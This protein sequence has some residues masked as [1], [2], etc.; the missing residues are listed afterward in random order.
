M[1]LRYLL[2]GIAAVL[3]TA[4]CSLQPNDYTLPGQVATGSNGYTA[5]VTFD[6]VANLV[7]NSAV[8]LNNVVVGTVASIDVS[9]NWQAK[10]KLRLLKSANIP[11]NATFSIGQKT[12]L[13]AQYVEVNMPATPSAAKL[14]NDASVPSSQTGTYPATE[15]VLGAVALLLNNGG[16][17][18]IQTITSQLSA[19]LTDHVPDSRELIRRST[20]LLAVFDQNKGQ[21]V[22]A[23][24]ALNR[25]SS[26]LANDQSALGQA[27]DRL[28]PGLKSLAQERQTLVNAVNATGRTGAATSQLINASR[29]GLLQTVD[30][31][32]PIL[33]NLQTVATTL[34]DALKIAVTIPFPVMT[35]G[36]AVKGDFANLF[37][38]LDLRG[39]SLADTWLPGLLGGLNLPT[40]ATHQATG[41]TTAKKSSSPPSSSPTGTAGASCVLKLLGVCL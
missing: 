40:T 17:S 3:T 30:G 10:V 14:V 35:T 20:Q 27:I 8:E 36:N 1:K 21:L 9:S 29:Q 23:L 2:V 22:G 31:L 41:A 6:Q 16:L 5:T 15:Q 13:G 38:T 4:G 11:A 28:G 32:Q 37:T 12:L 39:T 33:A 24:E 7:P 34:P 26:G 25:L 18:Q 19:A